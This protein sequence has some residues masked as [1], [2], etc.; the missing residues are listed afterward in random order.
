MAS[1]TLQNCLTQLLCFIHTQLPCKV[2]C[3][4]DAVALPNKQ[5]YMR[6]HSS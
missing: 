2:F 3:D 6:K 5:E 1:C 4:D